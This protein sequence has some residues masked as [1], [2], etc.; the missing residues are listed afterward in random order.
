[1]PPTIPQRIEAE[2]QDYASRGTAPPYRLTLQGI[3][4]H[5]G[6]STQPVRTAV[7]ALL[8]ARWM[9]REPGGLRLNPRKRGARVRRARETVVA[10]AE[11]ET[12]LTQQV[13]LRSLRGESSFLREEAV[14]TELGAG[15]TQLRTILTRLAGGGIVEHVPRRGWRI[16]AFSEQRMLE[17]LELREELE[18]FALD[19]SLGRLDDTRLR[20]LRQHNT[21]TRAGRPR[22]D[23]GLHRLWIE[24]CG[25]RYVREFFDRHGRYFS[26]LFD[27][28]SFEAE[29]IAEMASQH[30][31]ILSAL[32]DGRHTD[33]RRVLRE[34]I[35]AQR[36]N[37]G[38]LME[39]IDEGE[40]A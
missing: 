30:H 6:V 9:V 4:A 36:P 8:R 18:L 32:L 1:M 26:T 37:V 19:R 16:E 15:R 27:Y 11:L 38:R 2:L 39:R 33:A 29:V 22:I 17:Y 14:A 25:N 24:G 28:A 12:R 20:E 13:I 23:D 7:D 3:A 21:P 10:G 35:R 40:H 5:F 31:A 34:H